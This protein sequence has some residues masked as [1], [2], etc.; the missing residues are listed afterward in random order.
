MYGYIYKITCLI[1]NRSYIGQHKSSVFD[2]KYW[3]SGTYIKKAINKYGLENFSREIIEWV[4]S[5]EEATFRESH[6]IVEYDT[7]APKGYNLR[8]DL[9]IYGMSDIA[10]KHISDAKVGKSHRGT[11]CKEET[12]LKIS[13]KNKG[14]FAGNKN[15]YFGKKHS[16]EI[17][18]KIKQR[19]AGLVWWSKDNCSTLAKDCPGEGWVRGRNNI[20]GKSS[21][22]AGKTYSDELKLKLQTAHFGIKHSAATKLKMKNTWKKMKWY[23]NGIKNIRAV[24][25]PTGKEW[26][27]GRIKCHINDN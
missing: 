12:K 14:K 17:L 10:R 27:T 7:I 16:D 1:N 8:N 21:W 13:E 26:K 18:D 11:P 9:V 20:K 4:S 5:K 3:G 23:N 2:E 25:K 6:F 24:K 22:N 19:R 15:P